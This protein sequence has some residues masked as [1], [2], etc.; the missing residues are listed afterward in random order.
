MISSLLS[1][2]MRV[3]DSTP[4]GRM[5]NR[6]SKD[7]GIVDEIFPWAI[8]ESTQYI[9][10]IF[11]VLCVVSIFNPAMLLVLAGSVV[12]VYLLLKLCLRAVQDLKRL[13]G[14]SI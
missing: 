5:L 2:Q 10:I 8:V 1:A 9:L 11:G 12:V 4:S 13:D 3:F 6:F 14:I 7:M